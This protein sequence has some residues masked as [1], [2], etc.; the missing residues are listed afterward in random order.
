MKIQQ[1]FRRNNRRRSPFLDLI[2]SQAPCPR[3]PSVP[4]IIK[5]RPRN[6][7]KLRMNYDRSADNENFKSYVSLVLFHLLFTRP[8]GVNAIQTGSSRGSASSFMNIFYLKPW[9]RI[10]MTKKGSRKKSKNSAVSP[11]TTCFANWWG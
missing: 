1:N 7:K 6:K 11:Q 3:S 5:I 4:L 8:H 2:N 9:L 10:A